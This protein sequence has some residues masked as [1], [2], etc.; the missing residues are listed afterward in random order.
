[1][2]DAGHLLDKDRIRV[3]SDS[4]RVA[5]RSQQVSSWNIGNYLYGCRVVRRVNRFCQEAYPNLVLS[6]SLRHSSDDCGGLVSV[7][8]F[9]YAALAGGLR[10]RELVLPLSVPWVCPQ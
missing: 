10:R 4:F 8:D 9:R 7:T 5:C 3:R 6:D 2:G 1:M